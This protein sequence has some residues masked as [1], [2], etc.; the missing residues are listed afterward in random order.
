MYGPP[1]W[2]KLDDVDCGGDRQSPVNINTGTVAKKHYPDLKITFDNQRGLVT[3]E[4]VNNGHS[5]TLNI[6]K[7]EE[8]A[9]ITGGPLGDT[10]YTLIQFHIHFGCENSR[11]SEHTLNGKPFAGEVKT[12]IA[13][14]VFLIAVFQILCIVFCTHK[15]FSNFCFSVPK[16]VVSTVLVSLNVK[17]LT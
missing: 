4:L 11:G 7:S 14:F 2:H 10:T 1:D 15:L 13:P 3:G 6:E 17:S 5:P 9:E 16:F 12:Q 8:T